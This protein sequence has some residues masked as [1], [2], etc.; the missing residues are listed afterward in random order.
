MDRCAAVMC[1]VP[2]TEEEF[3]AG[4]TQ[5]LPDDS[6]DRDHEEDESEDSEEEEE[7]DGEREESQNGIRRSH[8]V[9]RRTDV[10][11]MVTALQQEGE[12]KAKPHDE[13]FI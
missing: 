7:E 4:L 5:E 10:V 8:S 3:L 13:C 12:T 2:Q 1:C 11:A 9:E 6:V